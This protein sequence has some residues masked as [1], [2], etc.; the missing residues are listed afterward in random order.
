MKLFE[1][2]DRDCVICGTSYHGFRDICDEPKCYWA[3]KAKGDRG[4]EALG[5]GRQPVS[6]PKTLFL[7]LPEEKK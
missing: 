6:Y 7:V 4:R 2:K 5:I 1:S 3:W